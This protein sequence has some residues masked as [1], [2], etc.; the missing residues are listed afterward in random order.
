MDSITRGNEVVEG[1]G[2]ISG[3]NLAMILA[4]WAPSP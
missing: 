2:I 3:Q 4:N 1:D